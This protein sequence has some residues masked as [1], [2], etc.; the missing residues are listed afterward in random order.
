MNSHRSGADGIRV[1]SC[2]LRTF[3]A[4]LIMMTKRD[5][6]SV[7]WIIA[8]VVGTA[9]IV[10]RIVVNA[11]AGW[12]R[13]PLSSTARYWRTYALSWFTSGRRDCVLFGTT[14]RRNGCE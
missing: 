2:A 11:F 10:T 12:P 9:L 1:R 5:W 3:R 4:T 13:Y 7:V 14:S 6:K 8:A